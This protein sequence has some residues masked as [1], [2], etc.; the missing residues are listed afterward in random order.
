MVS[1]ELPVLDVEEEVEGSTDGSELGSEEGRELGREDGSELGRSTLRSGTVIEPG[2]EEPELSDE[3]ELPDELEP[4][5]ELELL[6]DS[7][8]VPVAT[9]LTE[10]IA[11]PDHTVPTSRTP[12]ATDTRRLAVLPRRALLIVVPSSAPYESHRWPCRRTTRPCY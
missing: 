7:V 4:P 9:L 5:E 10:A 11:T 12:A 1:M 2:S 8:G 6:D 3:L